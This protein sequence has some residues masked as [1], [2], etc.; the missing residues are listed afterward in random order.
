MLIDFKRK[1]TPTLFVKLIGERLKLKYTN[2][3]S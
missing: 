2:H 1:L 3:R